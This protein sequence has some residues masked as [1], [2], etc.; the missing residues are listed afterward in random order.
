[1]DRGRWSR[2]RKLGAPERV[3]PTWTPERIEL[4]KLLWEEGVTTAEIGRRIGVTKNAVDR[5]G[6]PHRAG[7]ARSSRRRRR[8]A[9]TSSTSPARPAC[10]RSATRPT[11]ISI[12]AAGARSPASPTAS[13]TPRTP[14]SAEGAKGRGGVG[15]AFTTLPLAQRGRVTGFRMECS[16]RRAGRSTCR[17]ALSGSGKG[18][19][20]SASVRASRG[21]CRRGSAGTCGLPS[22]PGSC[23][24]WSC[25]PSISPAPG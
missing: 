9:A 11:T 5:Q 19:R 22:A 23:R 8:R 15:L 21:R 16:R 3:E 18:F 17:V 25:R 2:S 24:C 1:M 20:V 4:L 6:A 7:A 12:S 13:T 10:G 14:I